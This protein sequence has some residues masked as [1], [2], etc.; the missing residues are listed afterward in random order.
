[1][2]SFQRPDKIEWVG[3][4]FSVNGVKKEKNFGK[5]PDGDSWVGFVNKIKRNFNDDAKPTV[6][7]IVNHITNDDTACGFFFPAPKGYSESKY[8]L[9][10]SSDKFE[11]ILTKFDE[12]GINVWLQLEPG[13]NDLLKPT[14]ITFK[15]YGHHSCVKGLGID[16]EWWYRGDDGKGSKISDEQAKEV[17]DYV[18]SIN[19]E[20][21]VFVKHWNT[22][23]MPPTYRDG[24]I[25]I[26]DSQGFDSLTKAKKE[27]K[28]WAETYKD[29][30]VFFQI[31]YEADRELWEKR[32]ADFAKAI[33]EEVTQY[34]KHV[35]IIW[36][37]FTMKEALEKF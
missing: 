30:P 31:G 23:Y 3:F 25:F 11:E 34:N 32:P 21:T 13:N 26:D 9:F 24:L 16:L 8:I 29:N 14:E 7:V 1:M 33:A 19:P 17:V 12:E 10:D 2:I 27:F 5:V 4:R 22:K 37:D 15:Q 6:I 20:Y 35:G 18:R 36:V 28:E